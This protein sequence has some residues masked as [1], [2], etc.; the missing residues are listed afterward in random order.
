MTRSSAKNEET[1]VTIA[2]VA[3]RIT[4]LQLFTYTVNIHSVV[5]LLKVLHAIDCTIAFTIG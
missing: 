1:R 5:V 3:E 2:D 4:S